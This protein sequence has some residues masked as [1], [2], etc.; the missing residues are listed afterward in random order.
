MDDLRAGMDAAGS[1]RAAI[2]GVSEGGAMSALFAATY[3]EK[4][5]ALIMIGAYARRLRGDGYPWGP[6]AEE[7][8]EFCL[9]I[10]PAFRE[11]WAA[12]LRM[13]ASPGAALALT[14]MN[15]EIDIRSVL[16]A[17][18]VPTLVIHRSED[19][20]LLVEEGRYLARQI[21]GARF[22]ELPGA[23]HLPFAGD[24]ETM[25]DEI[26]EFLAGVR[27]SPE[28][29]RVLATV[30]FFDIQ[31]A[32]RLEADRLLSRV[33]RDVEWYRGVG[34]GQTVAMFDGP[35]RA[36]R[37]A[38]A[39]AQRAATAHA[40]YRAGLHTGECDK[41]GRGGPQG[42]GIEVAAQVLRCA[43]AGDSGVEYGAGFGGWIGDSI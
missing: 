15:G 29:D 5:W 1:K 21:P 13:G 24:S 10:H 36:V 4:T 22:L 11:G 37:C 8:E 9:E 31:A 33:G 32:T 39:M 14:R 7:R 43:G 35:A 23:D 3:P 42:P 19:R 12:Y 25:I 34:A 26:E 38:C 27:H 30:L 6:T 2:C 40:G 28:P 18:R 41:P 20:C 17:I 16:P